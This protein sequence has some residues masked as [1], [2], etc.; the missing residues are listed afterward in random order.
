MDTE[1][2]QVYVKAVEGR[3]HPEVFVRMPHARKIITAMVAI[4]MQTKEN[5]EDSAVQLFQDCASK[6]FASRSA[7]SEGYQAVSAASKQLHSPVSE[8]ETVAFTYC[9]Q[10]RS[11]L[12]DMFHAVTTVMF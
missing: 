1:L 8:E 5:D 4:A 3:V 2:H 11:D 7:F 6:V 12:H 9:T 10:Y